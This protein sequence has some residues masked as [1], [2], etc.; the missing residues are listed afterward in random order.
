MP[1]GLKVP[2]GVGPDGGAALVEGD[3][4]DLKILSLALGSDDNENAFQQNIGLG[5]DMI[6]SIN[7][8][9]TRSAIQRKV[10][11]IFRRFEAQERFTIR[12]ETITWEEDQEDQTMTMKFTYLCLE[13][14]EEKEFRLSYNT[15]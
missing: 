9:A 5:E 2:V 4:N 14:D 8:P 6:F 7:D 1:K 13:S 15:V 10:I 11:E 3:D 12:Q